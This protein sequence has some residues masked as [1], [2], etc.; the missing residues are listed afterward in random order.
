MKHRQ[1]WVKS[2]EDEP[3]GFYTDDDGNDYDILAM[4]DALIAIKA[5]TKPTA[6]SLSPE[7]RIRAIYEIACRALPEKHP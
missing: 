2:G 4:R 7:N 6:V 1:L 3:R 5:N